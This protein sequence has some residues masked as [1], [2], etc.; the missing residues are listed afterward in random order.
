[1]G[2]N[3]T[4]T[5]SPKDQ[6]GNAFT[7]S[8]TSSSSDLTVGTVDASGKFIASDPGTAMVNASNGSVTGIATVTVNRVPPSTTP[9][10]TGIV[11]SPSSAT[12]TAG[13]NQK[14]NATAKDQNGN[15]MSGINISWTSSN[16]AVGVIS[17]SNGITG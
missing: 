1:V 5:A 10:L 13:E 8:V 4:F 16:L 17:P 12:M 3:F 6:Y 11:V 9:V 2:D 14:F 15:P 7:A